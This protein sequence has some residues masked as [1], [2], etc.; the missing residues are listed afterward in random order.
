[1]MIKGDRRVIRIATL[2]GACRKTDSSESTCQECVRSRTKVQRSLSTLH[3]LSA[4]HAVSELYS[5]V[6]DEVYVQGVS[7]YAH[8]VASKSSCPRHV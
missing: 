6:A 5:A 2:E 4:S 7:Y 8:F 3:G 1:V